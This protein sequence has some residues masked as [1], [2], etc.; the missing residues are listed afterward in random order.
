MT[1]REPS[2]KTLSHPIPKNE[3]QRLNTLRGFGLLDTHP[4]DRFDNLTRLAAL[5]CHTPIAFISLVD[6]HR[7]WFKS[8]SIA[9]I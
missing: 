6:E 3:A 5:I 4:E 9:P 1:N 8:V 7:Q 2:L